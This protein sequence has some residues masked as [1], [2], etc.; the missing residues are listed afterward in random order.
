MLYAQDLKSI[1][2]MITALAF[3]VLPTIPTSATAEELAPGGGAS[4]VFSL[5]VT[6]TSLGGLANSLQRRFQAC[7]CTEELPLSPDDI[8]TA[9][10]ILE[11]TKDRP[12][13]ELTKREQLLLKTAKEMLDQGHTPAITIDSKRYRFTGKFKASSFPK[14]LDQLLMESPYHWYEENGTFVVFPRI[15]SRLSFPVTLNLRNPSITNVLKALVKEQPEDHVLT[16]H[17]TVMMVGATPPEYFQ[18]FHEL[19]KKPLPVSLVFDKEPAMDVLNRLVEATGG[20]VYW[21]VTSRGEIHMKPMP[22]F[23][24][25]LMDAAIALRDANR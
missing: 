22:A 24:Q 3:F 5:D 9:A 12:P 15:G 17:G 8:V 11:V 16:D 6:D 23:R 19:L 4:T 25:R 14:L 20:E 13:E 2:S 10:D 21:H 1:V 18:I 7:I